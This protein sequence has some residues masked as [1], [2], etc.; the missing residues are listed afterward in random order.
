MPQR[1]LIFETY[2]INV[3]DDEP[4]LFTLDG[5][6][7]RS[8]D[9]IARVLK[10][11][12]ESRFDLTSQA[13]RNTYGWSLREF[14]EYELEQANRAPILGLTLAR[15]VITRAGQTVTEDRIEDALSEFSPPTAETAHL[16]FYLSRHLVAV[17][18]NSAIMNTQLWRSSLHQLL[19]EASDA[20]EYTSSIRLEPVPRE[21]EVLNAF[22]S[23]T[24]LTRLRV[25][26]RLPNPELDRRTEKLRR[27]MID[28]SIR[29]YTQ[30][31][32]HS[33]GLSQAEDAL[34][35]A[36]A[37]MAQAG[38]KE[39]DV[40]LTGLRDGRLRTVRTGKKAVRGR[41]EGLKDYVR[42]MAANARS[43]E[44]QHVLAAI[45]DEV[46]RIAEAPTGPEPDR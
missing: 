14:V 22:R 41:L 12:T 27:E 38:Y 11:A 3:V 43:Q 21:E 6:P 39:G 24:K 32:R 20:L 44:A 33:K 9:E 35:F 45:M 15:S 18:Y 16:F 37:A 2:R 46:D 17:E 25:R 30:D 40:V 23:F 10:V 5:H 29:D 19:D 42:G 13:G 31:M 4:T 1:P 36:S 7:I 8:D 34:P 26:L 28:G